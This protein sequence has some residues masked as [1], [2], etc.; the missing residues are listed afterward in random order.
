MVKNAS[1][2][3]NET[4]LEHLGRNVPVRG[5]RAV[6]PPIQRASTILFDSVDELM[7]AA[8][9]R[10]ADDFVRYGRNGTV[11]Q[12]SLEKAVATLEGG[13]TAVAVP[14]GLA[15]VSLALLTVVQAG[16]HVLMADNVYGPA[17]GFARDFLGRFGVETTFFDPLAGA[18]VAGLFRDNTRCIYLESPG[19]LTFEVTDVPA[20]AAAA[21]AAGVKVVIDNTWAT[22]LFFRSFEHGADLVVHAGTKYLAGHSDVMIGLVV[23]TEDLADAVRRQSNQ[24]GYSCGPDEAFLTLRGLRTLA[25]RLQ[26]HQATGVAL[27]E[28]LQGRGEVARV[29][30]PALPGDPGHGLWRRDFLGASG[31]FGVELKPC[32]QKAVAALLDGLELFGMGYSWGGFESLAIP[33]FPGKMRS[34]TAWAGEGP[35]LRLHAGLEDPADLI[36]DLD[37]GFERL[38]TAA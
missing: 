26:R 10:G 15:A 5:G 37:A 24:V 6:N 3:S 28:W 34:A 1:A 14:S 9:E 31:L 21:H 25:V 30:H 12:I 35:L 4:L 18:E 7:A 13:A 33:A 11:T 19:S 23:A 38:R 2:P 17:R 27:A 36:A 20:V 32:S 16:D 22:P 8:S 29:L